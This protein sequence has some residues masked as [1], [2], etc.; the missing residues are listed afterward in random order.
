MFN[1]LT[2]GVPTSVYDGCKYAL[3]FLA[4]D[5]RHPCT[6]TSLCSLSFF[7]LHHPIFR[8]DKGTTNQ[9][10]RLPTYI[11]NRFSVLK[12]NVDKPLP[13]STLAEHPSSTLYILEGSGSGRR[14]SV[15]SAVVYRHIDRRFFDV[16]TRSPDVPGL[17]SL[18]MCFT[19]AGSYVECLTLFQTYVSNQIG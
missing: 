13:T 17:D 8:L 11:C 9:A 2:S 4:Y 14:G 12:I 7:F 15:P 19:T 18:A 3:G 6:C 10:A 16:R 1:V 5:I